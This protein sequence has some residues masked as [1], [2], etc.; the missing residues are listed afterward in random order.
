MA[1]LLANDDEIIRLRDDGRRPCGLARHRRSVTVRFC[2]YLVLF[3]ASFV[4][5]IFLGQSRHAQVSSSGAASRAHRISFHEIDD[6]GHELPE[7]VLIVGGAGFIG[8]HAALRLQ[9][10]G[11]KEVIVVD[12]FNDQHYSSKLK[13]E[14]ARIMENNGISV[15]KGDACDMDLIQRLIAD[16]DIQGIIYLASQ[17]YVRSDGAVKRPFQYPPDNMDCFVSSL[18]V[19]RAIGQTDMPFVYASDTV[20]YKL[21]LTVDGASFDEVGTDNFDEEIEKHLRYNEMI[22]R[23][24]YKLYG[25][26][27]MGI[28]FGTAVGTYGRPDMSYFRDEKATR[29]DK[30]TYHSVDD[31]VHRVLIELG[32]FA[33]GFNIATLPRQ[34]QRTSDEAMDGFLRWYDEGG[35]KFVQTAK[36][37]TTQKPREQANQICFVTSLFSD[38]P[39]LIEREGPY[40]VANYTNIHSSLR[41]YYFTNVDPDGLPPNGWEIIQ[42]KNMNFG[43]YITQ[44]RWPKF[45]GFRHRK[46]QSCKTI[47]YSDAN[48]P[49]KDLEY[50]VW[51]GLV[52]KVLESKDG[53]MQDRRPSKETIFDEMHSIVAREKD[54]AA[55]I[56]ASKKW[57]LEQEDFHDDAPGWW[58][59]ALIMDPSNSRLQELL[60]T[61][62][63]HYSEELG[64]WRDQPLYRYLVDKLDI[65]PLDLRLEGGHSRFFARVKSSGKHHHYDANTNGVSWQ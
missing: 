45:M 55:N 61:L 9:S 53:I 1:T 12:S 43:R 21:N 28:R 30:R 14:R 46:L 50:A 31:I 27:S 56:D 44:S 65:Q 32:S 4:V 62:W 23:A 16:H 10:D 42:L 59:M 48:R 57:F 24:Y 26:S 60:T 6:E 25:L 17:S 35:S 47:I 22:S 36:Q 52:E 51:K 11:V 40:P 18:D 37:K 49:P 41:Y 58:N 64:S 8:M 2:L 33:T 54:I 19:L 63:A 5:G 39:K 7:K 38:N 34:N 3:C 13:E 15:T 20:G 29:R